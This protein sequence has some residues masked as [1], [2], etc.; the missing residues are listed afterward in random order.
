MYHERWSYH[1]VREWLYILPCCLGIALIL[2]NKKTHLYYWYDADMVYHKG[3]AFYLIY[4]S[5]IIYSVLA[6][7]MVKK[8]T[9]Q[10]TRANSI[11][12]VSITGAVMMIVELLVPNIFL[13][14]FSG[15]NRSLKKR[16]KRQKKREKS[17]SGLQL[18]KEM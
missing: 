11:F 7:F 3:W 12:L 16:K 4:L 1:K 2:L 8:R 10:G 6:G 13:F 14:G 17:T 5:A 9:V 18:L 15:G